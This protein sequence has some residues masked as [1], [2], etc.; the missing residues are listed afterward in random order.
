MGQSSILQAALALS[1]DERFELV[2]RLLESLGSETGG[3]DDAAFREE[4][5]RRSLQVDNKTAK[6]IPWSELKNDTTTV[7]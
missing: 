2:E 1:D 5:D 7:E 6:L 3:I 4:L